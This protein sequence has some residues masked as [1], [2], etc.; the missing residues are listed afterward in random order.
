MSHHHCSSM[1]AVLICKL[2]YWCQAS[3]TEKCIWTL[4]SHFR[5]MTWCCVPINSE[6]LNFHGETSNLR[7]QSI[8]GAQRQKW[9]KHLAD[10]NKMIS[11]WASVHIKN[12]SAVQ[13]SLHRK[14]GKGTWD[15]RCNYTLL[16][17]GT[18]LSRKNLSIF[19]SLAIY[20]SVVYTCIIVPWVLPWLSDVRQLLPHSV[21]V[22]VFIPSLQ[23]GDLT[24]SAVSLYFSPIERKEML[25]LCA[26]W[27]VALVQPTHT[28]ATFPNCLSV[29][30]LL[31]RFYPLC[32]KLLC[33]T[34]F[35]IQLRVCWLT[36]SVL[37][38]WILELS[39]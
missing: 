37:T 22:D 16:F 36:L 28:F 26:N 17:C 6:G 1:H 2:I 9:T 23:V 3:C 10:R 35:C 38:H 33:K 27:N 13:L 19:C 8:P 11:L 24:S 14:R 7:P 12:P 18:F 25:E 5:I 30:L 31:F 21:G 20:N 34:T 29:S 4:W 32:F 15:N 39:L